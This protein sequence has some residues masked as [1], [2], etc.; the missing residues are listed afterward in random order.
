MATTQNERKNALDVQHSCNFNPTAKFPSILVHA[1]DV[2]ATESCK[3]LHNTV[4]RVRCNSWLWR[5]QMGVASMYMAKPDLSM[6]T[7]LCD[8][9]IPIF[10]DYCVPKRMKKVICYQLYI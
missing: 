3:N 1:L 10:D 7:S 9:L 8:T 4:G 5:I 6:C 2:P